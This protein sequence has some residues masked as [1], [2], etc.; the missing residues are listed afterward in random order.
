MKKEKVI[1]VELAHSENAGYF[2]D[3]CHVHSKFLKEIRVDPIFILDSRAKNIADSF[4][5]IKTKCYQFGLHDIDKQSKFPSFIKVLVNLWFDTIKYIKLMKISEKENA[6]LIN[7]L[8][9]RWLETL[10]LFLATFLQKGKTPIMLTVHVIH[11]RE[12]ENKFNIKDFI[13][14]RLVLSYGF[15]LRYL[16]K[17]NVVEKVIVYS[18]TIKSFL[19]DQLKLPKVTKIMYPVDFDYEKFKYTRKYSKRLLTLPQ[20]TKLLLLFSLEGKSIDNLF[21]AL[22]RFKDD[23]KIVI[24]GR[25]NKEFQIKLNNLIARYNLKEKL[26]VVNRF[27][28]TNEKFHFFNAADIILL[29]YN[30]RAY[31]RG[32][33]I[34]TILEET[35]MLKRPVIITQI[36]KFTE[37]VKKNKLGF[38]IHDTTDNWYKTIRYFLENSEKIIKLAEENSVRIRDQF[39]YDNVL[40]NIYEELNPT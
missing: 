30:E 39:R 16:L 32:A 3:H 12:I 17:R 4:K 15:L 23:F 13:S 8:T 29:P 5:K 11:N 20:N 1:L 24:A 14:N 7:V 38:V 34:S 33:G 31:R 9:F 28:K 18:D 25:M 10:P 36:G 35:T 22:P 27:I 21:G 19:T 37:I 40:R 6:K 2:F 26:I